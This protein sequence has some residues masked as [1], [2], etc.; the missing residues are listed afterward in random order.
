MGTTM[1]LADFFKY[2]RDNR[3]RI[4][5]IYHEVEE[6]QFQF[7]E[8]HTRQLEERQKL[9]TRY[10][11]LLLA[12]PADLPP[13]LA[14]LLQAQEQT[15]R[16]ALQ[17]QVAKLQEERADKGQKADGMVGQAQSELARIRQE[18]PILDQQE[19]ALKARRT[20]MEKELQGLDLQLKRLPWFPL[21]WLT[22]MSKR[23]QL[24]GQRVQLASNLQ[25]MT[26]GI[27]AVRQKWLEEK[28][29]LQE[30]QVSAQGQ[31]QALSV[32]TSQLQAR[33]DYLMAHL[34]ELSK[35][36][37]A[38]SV[39]NTLKELPTSDDTW[40]QRLSPL[41]ELNRNVANY[42]SGL[43]AVS[44]ILGV[45][46]GLGEGLDR[47]ARSVGTVYEEQRRYKL[48][49]LTLNLSDAVTTFH[50]AW[51]VIQAKVKDEKYLGAHPLE[52]SQN[53]QELLQQRLTEAALQRMFE[54]M[55]AALNAATKAWH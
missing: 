54:D 48:P 36:N 49:S 51:P 22:H 53:V 19:E 55:G 21:G 26:T 43:K 2:V 31:W 18:N 15:E 12:A 11:P 25:A 27:R 20:V 41:T 46:K 42:E 3:K 32:E 44:E 33:I 28:K 23:R 17:A 37:A 8:L 16:Q 52:F 10:V 50:A 45:L 9:L 14:R 5:D 7:N 13:D 29:K 1:N 30:G 4:A 47:F 34:D 24:E 6:I 39:L 40:K 38:Q 35:R